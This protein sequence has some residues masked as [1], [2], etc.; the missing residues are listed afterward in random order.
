MLELLVIAIRVAIRVEIRAAIP[1]V[2][3]A[4]TSAATVA[5]TLAAI[6]VASERLKCALQMRRKRANLATHGCFSQ[7]RPGTLGLNSL[8]RTACRYCRGLMPL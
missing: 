6:H 1:A 7:G 2:T 4:A 5:V 3:V 8:P